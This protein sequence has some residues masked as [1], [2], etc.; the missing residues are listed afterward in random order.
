MLLMLISQYQY[1]SALKLY[2]PKEIYN[3]HFIRSLPKGGHTL[4]SKLS[5][6][7]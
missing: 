1:C 4:W 5:H 6:E 3:L 7:S 2:S